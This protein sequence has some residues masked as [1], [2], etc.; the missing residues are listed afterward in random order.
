MGRP[1]GV[2]GRRHLNGCWP[3]GAS[4]F[5]RHWTRTFSHGKGTYTYTYDG[6]DQL[7]RAERRGLTTSIDLG[8]AS[9]DTDVVSGAY[10]VAGSLVSQMLPGGY[11]ESWVRNLAG[12]VTSLAYSQSVAG[13]GVPVLG[14][15]QS[16]DHL[17][18]VVTG[19]G[20][21]GSQRYG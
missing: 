13:V 10:D 19:T 16:Y 7:G 9:G 2:K 1:L 5:N 4:E 6:T 15:T 3:R 17:G 11:S 21:A 12:Q 14:F 20:P 18:R 8:Y